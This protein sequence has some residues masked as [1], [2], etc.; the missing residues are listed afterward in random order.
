MLRELGVDY[1]QGYGI[2]RP[3]PFDEALFKQAKRAVEDQRVVDSRGPD[4]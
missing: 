1:A 3:Q 2:G 4:A